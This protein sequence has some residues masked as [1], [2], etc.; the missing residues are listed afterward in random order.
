MGPL[1]FDTLVFKDANNEWDYS[2]CENIPEEK[3]IEFNIPDISTDISFFNSINLNKNTQ[4]KKI[5]IYPN[6]QK[7]GDDT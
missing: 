6:S 7:I 3:I 1:T 4:Q 5:N 2:E